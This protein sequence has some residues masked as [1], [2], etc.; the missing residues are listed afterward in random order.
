MRELLFVVI[1]AL[2]IANPGTLEEEMNKPIEIRRCHGWFKTVGKPVKRAK[3]TTTAELD[4]IK[5]KM[6]GFYKWVDT[7]AIK[8]N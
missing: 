8:Y 7:S 1:L 4:L 2:S 5:D 6:P 3:I